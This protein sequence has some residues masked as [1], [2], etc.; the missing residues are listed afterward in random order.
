MK[1][2]RLLDSMD[3]VLFGGIIVLL[4]K[5]QLFFCSIREC[6]S[7]GTTAAHQTELFL[8]SFHRCVASGL[9][10][11]QWAGGDAVLEVGERL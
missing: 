1:C 3:T 7:S 9:Y 6:P 8:S 2:N 5:H 11:T 4:V 10:P